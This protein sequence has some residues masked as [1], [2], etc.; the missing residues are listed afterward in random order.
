MPVLSEPIPDGVVFEQDE[1][2]YQYMSGWMFQG[3]IWGVF[4]DV[5]T[6]VYWIHKGDFWKD[7]GSPSHGCFSG[8][9]EELSVHL[10]RIGSKRG[11]LCTVNSTK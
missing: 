6:G 11:G 4:K 2:R 9:W 1:I 8:T 5:A 10:V 3:D 7:G